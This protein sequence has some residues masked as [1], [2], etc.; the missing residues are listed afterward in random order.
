M[1][2]WWGRLKITYTILH[3]LCAVIR[4][5][6]LEYIIIMNH[7]MHVLKETFQATAAHRGVRVSTVTLY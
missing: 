6:W 2:S 1:T 4:Q 7:S 3:A 5:T